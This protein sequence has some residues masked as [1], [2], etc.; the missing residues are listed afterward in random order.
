MSKKV[1]SWIREQLLKV[2]VLNDWLIGWQYTR[3]MKSLHKRYDS[4]IEKARKAKNA[5]DVEKL[6]NDFYNEY[7]WIRDPYAEW[8]S[9]Q[10]VRKARKYLISVGPYPQNDEEEEKSAGERQPGLR[11]P[12]QTYSPKVDR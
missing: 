3:D 6:D 10:I 5:K 1:W 8:Q 11:N 7:V 9:D 4:L 2:P 12:D